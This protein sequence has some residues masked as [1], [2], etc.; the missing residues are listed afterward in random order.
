MPIPAITKVFAV[1]EVFLK[2]APYSPAA[3]S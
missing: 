1:D 2:Y 3:A